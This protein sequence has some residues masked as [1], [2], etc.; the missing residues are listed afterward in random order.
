MG[1]A[2]GDVD[3]D[4]DH[5]LVFLNGKDRRVNLAINDG[6]GSFTTTSIDFGVPVREIGPLSGG[7]HQG[8]NLG[9]IDGDSDLD[10]AVALDRDV[11]THPD[12]GHAIFVND[13]AGGFTETSAAAA[14]TT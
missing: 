14:S 1:L 12:V 7:F 8:M 5:D 9:D 13:G 11:G 3:G 10:I 4:G 2:T 6:S